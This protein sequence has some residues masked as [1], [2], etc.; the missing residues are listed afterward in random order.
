MSGIAAGYAGF[1]GLDPHLIADGLWGVKVGKFRRNWFGAE[2]TFEQSIRV[3]AARYLGGDFVVEFPKPDLK[4][5]IP[6]LHVGAGTFLYGWS[7]AEAAL[8]FGGGIKQYITERV[9]VR[10]GVQDRM[11]LRYPSTH[12]VD[13][14][15]GVMFR[16]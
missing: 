1:N 10:F 4:G 16:F 5:P 12:L 2:F 7:H 6:F 15:G 13:F 3:P 8:S 11:V 9:G 14:Y